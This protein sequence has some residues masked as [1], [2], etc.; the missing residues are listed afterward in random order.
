M[1]E[2]SLSEGSNHLGVYTHRKASPLLWRWFRILIATERKSE[3]L[4]IPAT[5]KILG[6]FP[7]NDTWLSVVTRLHEEPC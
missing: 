4:P 5:G 1:C 3:S 7:R 2:G 6:E